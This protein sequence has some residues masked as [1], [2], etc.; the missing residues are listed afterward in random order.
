MFQSILWAL[1]LGIVPKLLGVA[2]DLLLLFV[3]TVEEAELLKDDKGVPFSGAKKREYVL[4]KLEAEIAKQG[5]TLRAV[6][7][8]LSVAVNYT[9]FLVNPTVA[10]T[11]APSV[12]VPKT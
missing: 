9:T 2:K 11:V 8:L 5:L 10:P 3:K 4:D 7:L 12:A 1:F 6:D